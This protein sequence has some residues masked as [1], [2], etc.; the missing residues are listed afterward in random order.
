M[1]VLLILLAIIVLVAYLFLEQRKEQEK[2]GIFDYYYGMPGIEK[3]YIST[4]YIR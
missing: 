1:I 4:G 2:E 3:T